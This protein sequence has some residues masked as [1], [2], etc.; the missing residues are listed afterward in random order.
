[1]MH[2]MLRLVTLRHLT[3]APLRSALTVFGTAIAVAGLVAITS[4][5]QS[6]LSS[7][8]HSMQGLSG[9]VDLEIG[10]GDMPIP[11]S[12]LEPLSQ[13][14]GVAHISPVIEAKARYA[15]TSEPLLI[16][17]VDLTG[18]SYFRDLRGVDSDV[19]PLEFL[20]CRRC[21]LL[22]GGF[23]ARHHIAAG[24]TVSLVTPQGP[25]PFVVKAILQD[26]GAA[27]AYGGNLAVMYL[28]AAQAVF[29]RN[30]RFDRIDIAV[31]PGMALAEISARLQNVVG[32]GIAV[33]S[34]TRRSGRTVDMMARFRL[35][36][37][38]V[39]GLALLVSMFMIYNTV[40]M[41]IAQRRREIGIL[42]ALGLLA[43]EVRRLFVGEALLLGCIGGV[44][45]VGLGAL[46][47][48]LVL[49]GIGATISN[50]YVDINV[51]D[52]AVSPLVALGSVAACLAATA[53]SAY[54]PATEAA[55]TAPAL[56][57]QRGTVTAL[58]V[59]P[60]R[61]GLMLAPVVGVAAWSMTLLP[62][63]ATL[64][65]TDHLC[66]VLA[67]MAAVCLV[68][69]VLLVASRLFRRPMGWL[70][71][72][73]GRLAADN[74][75]REGVRAVVT[76]SAL[77][78]GLALAIAASTFV[79]GFEIAV[80]TWLRQAVPA[81]LLVS[82]SAPINQG[83]VRMP[84]AL[85]ASLQRL[86][87]AMD[88]ERVSVRKLPLFDTRVTVLAVDAVLR[89]PRARLQLVAGAADP[90]PD[91]A[92]GRQILISDN[93]A[94]RQNLAPGDVLPL[95][96]PQG[97]VP[98]TVR[99]VYVDYNSDAGSIL[100]DRRFFV[101]D[102]L[103]DSV[104]SFEL[105]VHNPADVPAIRDAILT[106]LAP[107]H[108]WYVMTNAMLR[109]EAQGI[110]RNTFKVTSAMS[111]LAV[112]VALLGVMNTL[113]GAVF[114][115]TRELGVLRAVGLSRGGVVRLFVCEAVLLALCAAVLAV[116]AGALLG[117]L[118]VAVVNVRGTGW[119]IGFHPVWRDQVAVLLLA[120]VAAASAAVWPAWRGGRR[121][122][123]ESLMYE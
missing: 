49:R 13:V 121:P 99:A 34:P 35:A 123:T 100:L 60:W 30:G 106:T 79:H 94:F 29:E 70:F 22:A 54:L 102:F 20:N 7:Y 33:E 27:Q 17:G 50:L 61:L 78:V 1:M 9:R 52:A 48:Q 58:P 111:I 26:D 28:D 37:R 14:R 103:D 80:E 88:V 18:D 107:A 41:A 36:L 42:R 86:P 68:P 84:A 112:L 118:F 77:M 76:V 105:Y 59:L 69:A 73:P 47:A 23:A 57:M 93:L 81:D 6:V 87:F 45:G 115:R 64:G 116:G 63:E 24:T 89:A 119:H 12:L 40:G 82:G 90:W 53:L 2:H 4:A 44:L 55:R 101:A 113:I 96:T 25:L 104:D 85:A 120:L 97:L 65:A 95:P 62:S 19:D 3:R 32:P 67:V 71:G 109:A 56:S 51:G 72:V 117:W 110:V 15:P 31:T 16:L 11:E 75:T 122:I 10:T 43:E 74:L 83:N 39:S 91:I 92:A 66:M 114:D 21:I 5:N 38:V 108:D 46:L 8:E 98:Y